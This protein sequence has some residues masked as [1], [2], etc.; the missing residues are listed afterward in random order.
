[1]AAPVF[2]E[3]AWMAELAS[4]VL[5]GEP[6][7]VG[8]DQHVVVEGVLTGEHRAAYPTLVRLDAGVAAVMAD[9][10]GGCCKGPW[11]LANAALKRVQTTSRLH[12]DCFYGLKGLLLQF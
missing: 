2:S 9:E 3:V 6:R 5:A 4:T 8:V 12:P 11:R 10:C 7:L 1:M